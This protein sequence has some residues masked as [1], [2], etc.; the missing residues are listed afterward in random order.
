M[1]HHIT[2]TKDTAPIVL[3]RLQK[4]IRTRGVLKTYSK[5]TGQKEIADYLIKQGFKDR[6]LSVIPTTESRCNTIPISNSKMGID[7]DK[8]MQLIRLNWNENHENE[9]MVDYLY[10]EEYG[11]LE[12]NYVMII[13]YGTKL[14]ISSEK[15]MFKRKNW[16]NSGSTTF[17]TS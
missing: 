3:H 11:Q 4:M 13:P 17:I 8:D 6:I 5:Y 15:I 7:N 1:K 10:D 14:Y 2:L 12:Y 9:F 16:D